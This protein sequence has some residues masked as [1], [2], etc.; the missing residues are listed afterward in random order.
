MTEGNVYY[1]DGG[2]GIIANGRFYL[3]RCGRCREEN[4]GPAVADGRCVWCGDKPDVVGADR[5]A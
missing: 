3:K 5:T 2:F 1:G 4:Y